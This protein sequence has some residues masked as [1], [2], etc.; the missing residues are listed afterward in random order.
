M[1]PIL[2]AEKITKD[3]GK[4][5]IIKGITLVLYRETFTVILGP[6][7]S[8][9]S[10]LLNIL[11]GNLKP[12]T[13]TVKYED[14]IITALSQKELADWKRN[15]IGYV[16]QNYM[17]LNNLTAEENIKVG[18]SPEMTPLAFDRLTRILEIVFLALHISF[19]DNIHDILILGMLG[20]HIKYIRKLLVDVYL[21]V[22]WIV[23]AITLAPS[24]ILA[25][26]IQNSLS[27]STND[28]MPFGTNFLVIIIAFGLINII[29]YG[30][31]ATFSL[32]IKRII[33]KGEI[34][35]IIYA[36]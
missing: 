20:H 5:K 10:T 28:Y 22:L 16:F 2:C 6:S 11:S 25:R 30:V 8:G 15:S 27:V 32:R 9:K 23:F 31:Q 36:E 19:Q 24:I 29:Y 34:T 26:T 4:E 1:I 7:G 3:Y 35:D 18:I 14:K 17:L 33:A 12:T 13:G 21:P